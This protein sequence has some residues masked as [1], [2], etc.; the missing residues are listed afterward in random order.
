LQALKLFLF[1]PLAVFVLLAIGYALRRGGVRRLGTAAIAVALAALWVLSTPAASTWAGLGLEV[2]PALAPDEPLPPAEAI[3]VLAAGRR[4]GGGAYDGDTVGPLTL[5]RL[6]YAVRLH[7]R[8]G[9][10]ILATGG[11]S[12][13]DA[14]PLG[15]LMARALAED[16]GTPT[17]WVE[18]EARNTAQNAIYSAEILRQEGIR[19]VFVV[20]H[21]WHMRRAVYAFEAAGLTPVPAP[22]ANTPEGAYSADVS[23]HDLLPS[24]WALNDTCYALHEW[25]GLAWYRIRY[26]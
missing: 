12:E 18:T 4:S 11:L 26:G 19:R 21:A 25:L 6:R 2:H 7:R 23:L 13:E 14:P 3:V 5:E 9:L 22:M 17:R 8:S 24:P 1:P 16:F 10:P 20:T 15:D